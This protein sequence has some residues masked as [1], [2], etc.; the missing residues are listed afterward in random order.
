MFHAPVFLL[1]PDASDTS[2]HEDVYTRSW[3]SLPVPIKS[4]TQVESAEPLSLASETPTVFHGRERL[5]GRRDGLVGHALWFRKE[6]A[7]RGYVWR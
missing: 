6:A 2:S 4:F 1:S 5:A 7:R 3:E